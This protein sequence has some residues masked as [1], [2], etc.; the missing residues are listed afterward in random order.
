MRSARLNVRTIAASAAVLVLI[1]CGGFSPRAETPFA[2]SPNASGRGT[3]SKDLLYL[4][5]V[6]TN[7]VAIYGYPG[8]KAVGK[9]TGL[10]K[11]RSECVDRSGNVWIADVEALQLDK[12]EPGHTKPIAA[13]STQGIPSGCSVS[14]VNG[15]LAV[16][17]G[18]N[19]IVLSVFSNVHHHWRDARLFTDKTMRTGYFCGYDAEGNL[20]LDGKSSTGGFRLAE[21]P[22]GGKALVD[23]T[24]DQ[25]IKMPGQVQWDG[26]YVA[27]GDT[28]LSPS[29]VY[30]FSVSG[31]EA[32][33]TGATTLA[34]TRSVRQFW[35]D[36]DRIVG[37]DY[38]VDVGI[39]AYPAG[40]NAMQK[41]SIPGYGASVGAAP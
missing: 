11:P 29:V 25:T 30:Q 14:P 21:L 36:G 24:E 26:K 7:T 40:G 15:D 35:I 38:G 18:P 10:G 1:G 8:D 6:K 2:T 5:D 41:I 33:K 9:L 20:Y 17:G 32:K 12:F 22:H 23:L 37:P 19:G 13:L 31:H 39:W 3:A 16:A 34:G 28:S 4:S 27:I